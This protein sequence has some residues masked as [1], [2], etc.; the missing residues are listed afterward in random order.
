MSICKEIG[1]ENNIQKRSSSQAQ[2][3]WQ[4]D[5]IWASATA[6]FFFIC[7]SEQKQREGSHSVSSCAWHR[8]SRAT[9]G[10]L[11]ICGVFKLRA[12]SYSIHSPV[13]TR[14]SASYFFLWCVQV[15]GKNISDSSTSSSKHH[16]WV[17]KWTSWLVSTTPGIF[18]FFFL[19]SC[20]A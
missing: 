20:S 15:G 8:D 16:C 11:G 3:P 5:F 4:F 19:H 6:F 10:Q 18:F 17:V 1:K 12:S 9:F 14:S 7:V 2:S 13:T